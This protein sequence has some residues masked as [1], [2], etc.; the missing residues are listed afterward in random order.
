MAMSSHL[1]KFS[2]IDSFLTAGLV[3]CIA[4]SGALSVSSEKPNIIIIM[5]DDMGFDDVSFRGSNNFL[6]PNIDALAYCGV[7][8]NN[9][10]AAP[11]CTPSRAALLTGKYPINTGMQHYVIVNDQPWSLPLN[12][13]TMAEVFQGNGYRTSLL[14]KWHLGM[15]QR[16]FTPT[17]RGFDRHLGYLG[18]YVDYYS[19]SYEQKS[20]GYNGHD[21]RDNLK[22]S[23][24]QV[25]HYVTDVL[26]DAAI[27][28]I[29]DHGSKNNSQPLFLL[30]SHLAPHAANDDSPMQAPD[31]ELAQFE[32]IRNETHRYYAAMVSRLDRSVGMVI[33]AL[34]RQEML[35][36]SIV[37]F[38]SDNGGPSQG[39]HSTTASNYPLRGQKNSPWE[40]GL[41]SSAAIWST[42]FERL[43]SVWKQQIYIGDLLPT[44]AAA[45]GISPDPDLRLDGLNLWSALK[46]GYE[47]VEREIVHVID[48][49]EAEPHLSYTRGKWKVISGTTSGG[50]YDGWL[51]QRVTSEEDPRSGDYED[52]IRNTSVWQQLQR[53]SAGERNISEL[54]DQARVECPVPATGIKPCMP[55]EAPCLFDIE[56]DPCEQ[57]NLYEEYRNTTIFQDLWQRIQQFAKDA[58][59]PNNKPSD[60]DCNP[61]FYHNEWT[62]WQDEQASSSGTTGRMKIFTLFLGFIVTSRWF[63]SIWDT[64]PKSIP[65]I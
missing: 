59:P 61:R 38:L 65:T 20:N 63:V 27:Q 11:M 22:P 44:L 9:L 36:N 57:S 23:H 49:D 17:Q 1:G 10:Y 43:G 37:L 25:G 4:L 13:T 30:L 33:N 39:Q 5:A 19:Q 28:E 18:A 3:F 6:T 62:W 12:E 48:E 26:T 14:G 50:I 64:L 52:L 21:F 29:E 51:G 31:D 15:S 34:A 24:D 47:S 53:V 32:Y 40:G 8:L 54:R 58:H 60:P 7:I 2:S 41:R 35:Q 46:Y 16:N 56:A 45:A 42:E 55:L